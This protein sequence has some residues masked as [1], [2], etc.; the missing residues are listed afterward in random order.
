MTPPPPAKLPLARS[1]ELGLDLRSAKLRSA[2]P[3]PRSFHWSK[4]SG[5]TPHPPARASKSV[6]TLPDGSRVTHKRCRKQARGSS[7]SVRSKQ[8][9]SDKLLLTFFWWSCIYITFELPPP[10]AAPPLLPCDDQPS[11][12]AADGRGGANPGHVA[13]A[14][15]RVTSTRRLMRCVHIE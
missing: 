6:P 5:D 4:P 9:G 2:A 10:V 13:M 7:S 3:E 1:L 11:V 15:V 12:R 14:V 8:A